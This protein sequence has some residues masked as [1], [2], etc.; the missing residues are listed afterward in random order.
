VRFLF[1]RHGVGFGLA[2][3]QPAIGKQRHKF[4]R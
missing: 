3:R 1:F 4:G 2:Q